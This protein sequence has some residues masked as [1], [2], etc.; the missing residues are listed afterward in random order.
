MMM[1]M[2]TGKV[3]GQAAAESHAH[4]GVMQAMEDARAAAA[5]AM[6]A[7]DQANVSAAAE[8][9]ERE[10]L[11]AEMQLLRQE[12]AHAQQVKAQTEGDLMLAVDDAEMVRQYLAESQRAGAVQQQMAQQMASRQP[13]PQAHR[14]RP[15]SRSRTREDPMAAPVSRAASET[16]AAAAEAKQARPAHWF[17]YDPVR[18]VNAIP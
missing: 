14:G 2:F 17:P 12:L 5:A 1:M 6:R 4:H 10:A 16:L 7:A 11:E 15:R 9:R 13:T 3:P 8:R 18:V